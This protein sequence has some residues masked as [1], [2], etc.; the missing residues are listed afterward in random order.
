MWKLHYQKISS[1]P[2]KTLVQLIVATFLYFKKIFQK[3]Q[4]EIYTVSFIL[5]IHIIQYSY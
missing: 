4:E 5:G 2:T 1:F 3:V